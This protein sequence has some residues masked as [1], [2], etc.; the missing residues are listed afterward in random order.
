MPKKKEN[1]LVICAHSDDQVLGVGGT[2]AKYAQERKNVYTIVFSY[3]EKSHPWLKKKVTADMRVKESEEAQKILGSKKTIFYGVEEGKFEDE[4]RN[5]KIDEK[6]IA[7]IKKTKPK[8][9]FLHSKDDPHPDHNAVNKSVKEILNR[10]RYKGD[11][12]V[13]DIWNPNI[14]KAEN[15]KMYVNITDT[16]KLKIK[17]IKCFKSQ[18]MAVILLLWSVYFRALKNGLK[19]D[20]RYAELFFKVR[21][22]K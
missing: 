5:K 4:I 14:K 10:M 12:Y 17:A 1:I 18:W 15:P 11:I 8:K 22:E 2:I 9:I 16:F 19:S 6:L 21:Q 7:F 13:F 3:G 20:C